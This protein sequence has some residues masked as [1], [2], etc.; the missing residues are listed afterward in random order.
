MRF[1]TVR[2]SILQHFSARTRVTT[3]SH[4]GT[5]KG[6]IASKGRLACGAARGGRNLHPLEIA[7]L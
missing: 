5:R 6:V 3:V 1:H 4:R 2:I 7:K